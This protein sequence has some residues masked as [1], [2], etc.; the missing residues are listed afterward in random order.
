MAKHQNMLVAMLALYSGELPDTR[1]FLKSLGR[2]FP[3]APRPG[4]IQEDEGQILFPFGGNQ[5]VVGLMPVA[6]PWSDLEGPCETAWWWPEAAACM[7][8]HTSHL[9]VALMGSSGDVKERH[10]RLTHLVAALA[11]HAHAAGIYW[12]NGTLVHEP[13]A[14]RAQAD[15]LTVEHLVPQLWIDMRAE[16]NGDGSN[17]FFTTGMHAFSQLEIEIERTTLGAEPLLDLIYPTIDY[18]LTSGVRIRPGETLGRSATEQIKVTYGPS[19]FE[20]RDKVMKFALE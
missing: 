3:D 12:G 16:R 13:Q 5:A 4:K 17:R 1:S 10:V 15:G 9:I 8:C 18:I 2:V 7:S 11:E 14:F 19:M 6:I 20:S